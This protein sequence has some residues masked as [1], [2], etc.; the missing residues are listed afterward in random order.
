MFFLKC[1]SGFSD[2]ISLI[3][4]TRRRIAG[5]AGAFFADLDR[6]H[7]ATAVRQG[8]FGFGN[9]HDAGV[10][11]RDALRESGTA[12]QPDA[13]PMHAHHSMVGDWALMTHYNAFL[14]YDNQS[15]RRGDEQ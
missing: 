11:A 4:R 3:Q 7:G 14:A 9:R 8:G 12:W 13:T 6:A 1:R 5:R 15:G 2:R 10:G